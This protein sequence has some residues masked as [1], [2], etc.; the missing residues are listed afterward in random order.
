MFKYSTTF[1]YN[2]SKNIYTFTPPAESSSG[3]VAAK[4]TRQHAVPIEESS[5][6]LV[7]S[8]VREQLLGF[9]VIDRRVHDHVVT[10]LPV[11]GRR[12]LVLVAE[13]QS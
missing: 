7:E 8:H 2:L 5:L 6:Y 4:T 3:K 12:H 9:F 11:D 13:L 10:L 1:I